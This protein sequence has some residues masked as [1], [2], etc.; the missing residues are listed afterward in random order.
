MVDFLH[1]V[2]GYGDT[3]K[4]NSCYRSDGVFCRHGCL[5]GAKLRLLFY[6]EIRSRC[7]SELFFLST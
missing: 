2:H 4:G 3:S 1:L 5:T 6:Q 7:T